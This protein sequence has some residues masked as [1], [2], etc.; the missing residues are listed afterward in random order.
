MGWWQS[1]VIA[2][3]NNNRRLLN[4]VTFGIQLRVGRV[5]SGGWPI[6]LGARAVSGFGLGFRVSQGLILRL[7]RFHF[8]LAYALF[9]NVA[10]FHV[11]PSTEKHVNP[12]LRRWAY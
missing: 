8:D 7:P 5:A 1:I 3:A 6:L 4:C 9:T 10:D 12:D 11:D 2:V